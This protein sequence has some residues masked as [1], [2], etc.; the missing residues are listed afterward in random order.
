MNLTRTRRLLKLIALLQ[1]ARGFNTDALALACEVSRR[2]IFRD[3]DL[4]RESGL[5]LEFDEAAQRYRIS[6]TVYLPPMDFTAEEALALTVLCHE[7][8]DTSGLPFLGPASSAAVKLEGNLPPRLRKHLQNLARAVE[9]H[10]SP[11]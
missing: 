1:T 11:K 7:L 6:G 9:I 4:L 2:T 10:A 8:G 3:L 5:P